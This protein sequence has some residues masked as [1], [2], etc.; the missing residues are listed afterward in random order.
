L[1]PD[2]QTSVV[3]SPRTPSSLA[4]NESSLTTQN[5][6]L[7]LNL[8]FQ[9]FQDAGPSDAAAAATPV[10]PIRPE[11][12]FSFGVASDMEPIERPTSISPL[13]P[14][15]E[16]P[17]RPNLDTNLRNLVTQGLLNVYQSITRQ[18]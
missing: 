10:E 5:V 18:T 2:G 11:T 16:S 7:Y 8:L 3:S 1:G 9:A 13:G 17:Q 4:L 15:V 14:R 12:P 6:E